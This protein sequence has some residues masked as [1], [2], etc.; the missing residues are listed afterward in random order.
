MQVTLYQ[1]AASLRNLLEQIDPETGELPDGYEQARELVATKAQAVCAWVL[2]NERQ[3]EMVENHAKALLDE[4][5]KARKRSD[6]FRLYLQ[7]H[8]KACGITEIKADDFTFRAR[9]HLERDASVDVF[10]AALVPDQYRVTKT[11]TTINKKA[12]AEAIKGGTEVP[13][14]RI[15]KSDRLE[16]K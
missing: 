6:H 10:E 14:A 16:I 12:I 13:G 8:M 3:A 5:R 15:K 7:E 1:A 4:V 11:E 2:E 9:L